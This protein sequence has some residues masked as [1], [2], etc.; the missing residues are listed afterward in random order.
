MKHTVQG[1]LLV[2]DGWDAVRAHRERLKGERGLAL[3]QRRIPK[4]LRHLLPYASLLAT[5]EDGLQAEFWKLLP[6]QERKRF[7]AV[8]EES[9]RVERIREVTQDVPYSA[10]MAQLAYLA[11]TYSAFVW[12]MRQERP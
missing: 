8:M 5:G 2:G 12:F 6:P 4:D 10:E 3:D 7:C 11:D 1:D 9:D